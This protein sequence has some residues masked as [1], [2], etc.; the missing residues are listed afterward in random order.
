MSQTTHKKTEW[1]LASYVLTD[2]MTDFILSRQAKL[3][4]PR[5][6]E[7]YSWTLGKFLEWLESEGVNRPDEITSRYVRGYLAELRGRELADSYI[8]GHARAIKTLMRFFYTEDYTAQVVKFDMP[9][10]GNVK[11]LVL[12]AEKVRQLLKACTLPRDKALILLMVDTGLRRAEVCA[13]NWG[14]V[15][16]S[17]G[18]VQVERG[19]GGKARAVV[20]GVK[21][22][23]AL[24]KYR[25][26]ITP[27]EHAPMFQTI[28]GTRLA[29]SG[30]RSALLRIG[31]R[32]NIHITPHALR[33]TFA[34]LSLRAGMNLLQLQAMLGH[35]SLEMT[36]HYVQM[37]DD[38]LVE[39]HKAHGSID[40]FL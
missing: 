19:K 37:I 5:T 32:A 28:Q 14:N 40:S 6:V 36:R 22:R 9:K 25:R 15:D 1:A 13:L 30:L 26:E 10:V 27:D 24:L 3:C 18:L 38:D 4:T 20:V 11:L 31:N 34:T 29:Y 2:A 12:N 16:I 35:S 23:R 33:R 21:T 8:H 39:A 17:S 7:W